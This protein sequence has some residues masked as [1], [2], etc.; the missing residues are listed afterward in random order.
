[1]LGAGTGVRS[2][3]VRRCCIPGRFGFKYKATRRVFQEKASEHLFGL[4]FTVHFL[5]FTNCKI[6][7][8]S[9]M[10]S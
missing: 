4:R 6:N 8:V 9:E 2:D 10:L 3:S 5:F 1:M 7:I